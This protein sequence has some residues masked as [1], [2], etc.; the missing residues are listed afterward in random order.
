MLDTYT[1]VLNDG[2]VVTLDLSR[3]DGEEAID[4]VSRGILWAVNQD[5]AQF[6][7]AE[8]RERMRAQ[9]DLEKSLGL[10]P[11]RKHYQTRKP[12]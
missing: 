7:S 12:R 2:F 5:C 3:D 9:R 4:D 10:D 1:L 11:W 6:E 8:R